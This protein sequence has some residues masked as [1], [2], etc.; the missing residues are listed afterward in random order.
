MIS[1]KDLYKE[2]M[3][4]VTTPDRI[5]KYEDLP[6][7]DKG[8]AYHIANSLKENMYKGHAPI[9]YIKSTQ[10]S[11]EL[12]QV[13]L[14]NGYAV[15]TK[16]IQ[17]TL[18]G[19]DPPKYIHIWIPYKM[20]EYEPSLVDTLLSSKIPDSEECDPPLPPPS[21]ITQYEIWE[22]GKH[23]GDWKFGVAEPVMFEKTKWYD[24]FKKKP[25]PPENIT[26]MEGATLWSKNSKK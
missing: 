9:T 13:L 10:L 20:Q 18:L 3:A 1:A 7:Y 11:D 16:T 26:L 14:N 6:L 12:K 23:V 24:R 17:H 8:M 21:D 5:V 22:N 2:T 4:E 15:A 25:N 19:N